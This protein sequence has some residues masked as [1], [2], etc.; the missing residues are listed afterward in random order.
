M[1]SDQIH[2][3]CNSEQ[4]WASQ[5]PRKFYFDL[6]PSDTKAGFPVSAFSPPRNSSVLLITHLG[7]ENVQLSPLIRWILKPTNCFLRIVQEIQ[8]IRR[9]LNFY[10]NSTVSDMTAVWDQLGLTVYSIVDFSVAMMF[11]GNLTD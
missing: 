10:H 6:V 1:L 3:Y 9:L 4:S 11:L 7:W 8:M 5:R 2:P